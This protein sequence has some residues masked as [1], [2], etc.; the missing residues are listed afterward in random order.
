M[1][2]RAWSGDS[3][4]TEITVG[5]ALVA[6][7]LSGCGNLRIVVFDFGKMMI[8]EANSN[9]VRGCPCIISPGFNRDGLFIAVC[10]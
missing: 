1:E 2:Q 7:L 4:E 8:E 9:P 3:G 6:A 5:A 10:L